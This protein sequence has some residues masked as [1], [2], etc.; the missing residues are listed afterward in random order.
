M[1]CLTDVGV[2]H[3][4]DPAYPHEELHFH[5]K[6]LVGST[7]HTNG[8]NTWGGDHAIGAHLTC[9]NGILLAYYLTGDR[10]YLD[11]VEQ[12]RGTVTN[13]CANPNYRPA[14]RSTLPDGAP[15]PVFDSARDIAIS[16]AS[17]STCTSSITTQRFWRCWDRGSTPSWRIARDHG[18]YRGITC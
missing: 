18:D 1:R 16:S 11:S 12:W 5:Q 4:D 3:Y 15:T 8:F 6:R 2:I 7:K 13:D 14:D 9:Y 10:S 17:S